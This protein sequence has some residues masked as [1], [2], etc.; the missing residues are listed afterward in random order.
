MDIKEI[1]SSGV[2]EQYVLGNLS[3]EE[4]LEIERMAATHPEIRG[5]IENISGVLEH[6]ARANAVTPGRNVKAFLM[7]TI[8]FMERME[9]GEAPSSPP[10]L[11]EN[12]KRID[13]ASWLDREDMVLPSGAEDIYAKI[14]GNENDTVTAI[15][16]IK[17]ET[18]P[19]S[20]HHEHEKFLILEGTCDIV[21]ETEVHR[22][23]P[24][25]YFAIPLHK[26]HTVKVTSDIPCKVILQRAAA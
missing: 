11:S 23:A 9:K 14:I 13:F 7:A 25:D 4:L 16:W 3:K 17:T 10:I 6:L 18:P 19:E 21:V 5:E 8:D 2:L 20:H 1:I 24:G 22:L 12:S 15:V 26:N